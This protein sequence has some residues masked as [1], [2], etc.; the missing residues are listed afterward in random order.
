MPR[1][2]TNESDLIKITADLK[3]ETERAYLIDDG[4]TREWVAKS[5]VGDEPELVKGSTFVFEMPEWLAHE[6]GFI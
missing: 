3:H 2:L 6:K 5:L 4:S 1:R